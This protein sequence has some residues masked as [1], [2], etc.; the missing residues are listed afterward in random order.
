MRK[1][2]MSLSDNEL[3]DITLWAGLEPVPGGGPSPAEVNISHI[4]NVKVAVDMLANEISREKKEMN[5][6]MLE[7]LKVRDTWTTRLVRSATWSPIR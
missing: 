1:V 6:W 7:S 4:N 3:S 5:T 2:Y